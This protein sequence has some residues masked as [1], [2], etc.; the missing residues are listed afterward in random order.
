MVTAALLFAPVFAVSVDGDEEFCCMAISVSC[1]ACDQ[2]MTE[3]EYCAQ[4][5][6]P[7]V[8]L[9]ESCAAVEHGNCEACLGL[10]CAMAGGNCLENCGIL[11]DVSCYGPGG[12]GADRDAAACESYHEEKADAA[13]CGSASLQASCAECVAQTK[14]DGSPCRWFDHGACM[15]NGGMLGPGATQCAAADLIDGDDV[16][17]GDDLGEIDMCELCRDDYDPCTECDEGYGCIVYD[18]APLGCADPW[19]QQCPEGEVPTL[20]E[21]A[22]CESCAPDTGGGG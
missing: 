22:C 8:C 12:G 19:C 6:T 5:P 3:E 21:G 10:G 2:G 9:A 14:T 16:K 7:A 4:A 1:N 18:C 11:T 15:A 20:L 17:K 13:A